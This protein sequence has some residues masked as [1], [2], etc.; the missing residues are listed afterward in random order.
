[1]TE[2]RFS[3]HFLSNYGLWITGH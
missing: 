2:G 1:M 3:T